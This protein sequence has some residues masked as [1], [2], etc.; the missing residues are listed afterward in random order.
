MIEKERKSCVH[1][2]FIV[3]IEIGVH[4]FKS[5]SINVR[6]ALNSG[7]ELGH[8]ATVRSHSSTRANR[9][10]SQVL[11]VAWILIWK[12]LFSSKRK[13]KKTVKRCSLTLSTWVAQICQKWQQF[14]KL[15]LSIMH[16]CTPTH[17][18]RHN[19]QLCPPLPPLHVYVNE[20]HAW[21]CVWV[22]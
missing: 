21:L 11:G 1:Y 20:V 4:H 19:S 3:I 16:I 15:P 2:R 18:H 12:V 10:Q 14:N 9:W 22:F 8:D 5:K 17:T 6:L 7:L 13:E